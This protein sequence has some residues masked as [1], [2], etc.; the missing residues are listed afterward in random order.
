MTPKLPSKPKYLEVRKG[1]DYVKGE[2]DSKQLPKLFESIVENVKQLERAQYELDAL[3][4]TLIVNFGPE[5]ISGLR[6]G[7][8]IKD[9]SDKSNMTLLVLVLE[10]LFEKAMK[11]EGS[12]TGKD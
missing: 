10:G 8:T 1:Y 5:G 11:N 7:V 3:R 6:C 9:A 12:C 4:A 2:S